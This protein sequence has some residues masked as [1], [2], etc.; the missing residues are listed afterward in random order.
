MSR[1]IG[2]YTA[3][4]AASALV[5][6]YIFLL[7]YP[8]FDSPYSRTLYSADGRLLGARVAWDGQWRFA[9]REDAELPSRYTQAVIQFEDRRF[10]RHPGVSIPSI[11]RAAVDNLTTGHRTSGASTLTMQLVRLSRGNPPRTVLE[12]IS[13]M[14]AATRIE[15]SYTKS[16][17]LAL[18]AAHAPF[19]GNIVGVEAAS[20]R[21]FERPLDELTWAEAATLAV[22][23]NAPGLIHPGRGQSRLLDK[24]NRLLKQLL[25]SRKIDTLDYEIALEEPLPTSPSRLPANAPHLLD[26]TQGRTTLDGS[27]QI[28]VQRIID[29]YAANQLSANHIS[30]AAAIVADVRTGHVM[31][32]VGNVTSDRTTTDAGR[33]VD[34]IQSQRSTGSL[35]KPLLYCAMLASG[36]IMPE[37]L[38]L[39][40]PLNM[41]G[42]TPSNYNRTFS[43][44]VTTREAIERS[45]NVP[46]VRMLRQHSIGRFLELMRAL[47]MTTLTQSADHYGATLILGGCE[48]TL[49]EIT[50]I[51][52]SL[53]RALNSYNSTGS[54]L[55]DDLRGVTVDPEKPGTVPKGATSTLTRLDPAA[56]WFTLQ[57]MSGVNRPEEEASWQE[58]STTKQ[59]AWKT[60]T[61][62]GNRDAWAVG[63]TPRYAVGVWVG[64]ADGAGRASMT[65]VGSAAPIMFDIFAL[66]P[67]ATEGWFDKP[68]GAMESI[69]VCRRSG[70]R[71][72][73]WCSADPGSG[74]DTL[75][76]PQ[77]ALNSPL[78]P[79][80]HAVIVDSTSIGWFILPPAAEYYYRHTGGDYASPPSTPSSADH[81]LELIYP[82]AGAV[83]YLPRGFTD[84]EKFV[85]R[86]AH[87]RSSA[88]VHWHLDQQ[89][90]GVTYSSSVAGHTLSLEIEPGHHTLTIVD[91][92]GERQSINFTVRSR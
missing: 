33:A 80:H 18:Y 51:Y 85:L 89:Y 6:W 82:E 21:Y 76:M 87:R 65:G 57:A 72:S 14:I 55:E 25:I 13:E 75:D 81:P 31:A 88:T 26:R 38:V 44:V 11:L 67:A 83:L 90:L 28:A 46:L 42:F 4:C 64:N 56:I 9:L 74:V 53:A 52:A 43:G 54:Y 23:P 91:E 48:G 17:I 12:K 71:A 59:V 50:G 86:A 92:L 73:R 1:K 8:L 34:I 41:T 2:R 30:N 78:C 16:E 84:R 40:T 62:Y 60:G 45:L 63:V 32:Y 70:F 35:L 7:P 3:I 39:D 37:S 66:L 27:L 20:W 49:W 77:V 68:L 36:E 47:G 10:Y 69:P 15:W 19:G 5:L 22:L 24:R 58:F 61:S 79:Y 29:N